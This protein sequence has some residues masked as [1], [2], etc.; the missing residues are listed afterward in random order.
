[1][2][3]RNTCTMSRKCTPYNRT[4][5]RHTHTRTHTQSTDYRISYSYSNSRRV[6]RRPSCTVVHYG[7]ARSH[8]QNRVNN[9]PIIHDGHKQIY[10]SLLFVVLRDNFIMSL[11]LEAKMWMHRN[12]CNREVAPNRNIAPNCPRS[13]AS[14]LLSPS[15]T[16]THISPHTHTHPNAISRGVSADC[17][18]RVLLNE[19][20]MWL[21]V[22]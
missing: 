18:C 6:F 5:L 12:R 14:K 17:A 19:R 9:I 3:S 22:Q 21:M 15:H 8:P 4:T 10:T 11:L 2:P 13:V 7:N 1:M 20:F 16:Q